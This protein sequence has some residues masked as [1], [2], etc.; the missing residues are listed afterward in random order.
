MVVVAVV[1]GLGGESAVGRCSG[2]WRGSKGGEYGGQ[3][4]D[5]DVLGGGEVERGG[6]LQGEVKGMLTKVERK[7]GG[8]EGLLCS[9][10][11][12]GAR[13]RP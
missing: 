12:K 4:G 1:L 7:D 5:D 10:S 9:P 8:G 11:A 2:H 13:G 6:E 3:S